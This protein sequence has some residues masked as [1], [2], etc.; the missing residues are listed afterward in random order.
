MATDIMVPDLGNEVAEAEVIEWMAEE[1]DLVTK[2]ETVVV[3][4]TSKTELEIESPADGTL[5]LI[6]VKVGELTTPGAVLGTVH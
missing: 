5:G 4:S 3:I 1:G 2:G 6:N